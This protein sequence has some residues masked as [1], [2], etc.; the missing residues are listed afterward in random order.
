M[1]N[2]FAQLIFAVGFGFLLSGIGISF[3]P[4]D[5]VFR[6]F[7]CQ[8]SLLFTWVII[9]TSAA[10]WW[11]IGASRYLALRNS[12]WDEG[13]FANLLWMIL[14]GSS[15]SSAI[16]DGSYFSVHFSPSLFLVALVYAPWQSPIWLSGI[17]ALCAGSGALGFYLVARRLDLPKT[18][19]LIFALIWAGNLA[20][21]GAMINDF[22]EVTL[23]SGLFIWV[24]L[25]AL[26]RRYV[27]AL[28]LALAL[29]GLKEDVPV[30]IGSLG[31][32]LALSFKKRMIG[33]S[34]VGVALL[35]YFLVQSII[36][37]A[38]APVHLDF[39]QA[40]F[41]QLFT[42]NNSF[43]QT[44]FA[45]PFSLISPLLRWDRLWGFVILIMPVLCLPFLRW[46]WVGLIL[47][48][49]LLFAMENYNTF[50]FAGYYAVPIAALVLIS[51]LP[52]YRQI[53][54]KKPARLRL[55]Q[56][57]ML[58]MTIGATF[59]NDMDVTCGQF[60]RF[61]YQPHR[62]LNAID[63]MATTTASDISVNADVF[64]GSHFTNR[65]ALKIFPDNDNWIEDRI[66]IANRSLG[67]PSTILAI[68]DL[69]YKL[70]NNNPAFMFLSNQ[71]GIDAKAEY[72]SRL[73][74]MEAE[75]T[76][77]PLW[78]VISDSRASGRQ[79][80]Y[81]PEG[82]ARGDRACTTPR[83]LLPPGDY[84]YHLRIAATNNPARPAFI[85]FETRFIENTGFDKPT[86]TMLIGLEFWEEKVAYK[87]IDIPIT[88]TDWGLTYLNINF[89]R[90][91]N[92]RWDGIGITGLPDSFDAYFH[93]IFPQTFL[94][95][96][97]CLDNSLLID[98]KSSSLGQV[99]KVGKNEAGK[100]VCRWQLNAAIEEGDYWLYYLVNS[101]DG[102]QM[103]CI[104][105]TLE[106]VCKD[107]MTEVRS[108]LTPLMMRKLNPW[109][110]EYIGHGRKKVHIIPG[111][112]LEIRVN[113]DLANDVYFYKMWLCNDLIIEPWVYMQ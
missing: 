62:F 48:L 12:L 57:G 2:Y 107:G 65:R 50:V 40:R 23:A 43:F 110:H 74:W 104:W 32:V 75:A 45:Y 106:E 54:E 3:Y 95:N 101:V 38:I 64:I 21:R 44:V 111:A 92:I 42:E 7:V 5:G 89:G 94:P 53:A 19:G 84:S 22:H 70:M 68:G 24:V 81:I 90:Q 17:K 109:E 26:Q 35:Y 1:E 6:R 96:Q 73:R 69:G 36:W 72:M 60:D 108:V 82:A 99:V 33:W 15:I 71:G 49:W 56:W 13:L 76:T 25:L 11:I 31:I 20:L 105:A 87:T 18:T 41:P 30:Y 34:L 66:Y 112:I 58:G 97:G 85:V 100:V 78:S 63:R 103:Q 14:H 88:I 55:L 93:T 113:E 47:P 8:K 28:L 83:L 86:N 9:I 29:M 102:E 80:V 52:G 39:F 98:E 4:A 10:L 27:W 61:A 59:A 51:A 67:H 16:Y 46:G 37:S 79:T 77:W 91:G